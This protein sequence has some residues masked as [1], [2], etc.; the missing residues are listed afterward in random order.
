M[1]FKPLFDEKTVDLM[2]NVVHVRMD[3][4]DSP[5]WD[6]Y[7]VAAVPTV[8]LF[9]DG[10]VSRRIDSLPGNCVRVEKFL[11]WLNEIKQL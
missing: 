10:K 8:I 4:Y 3:N 2:S 7:A 6:E 5:L 1:R 11:A 9:E